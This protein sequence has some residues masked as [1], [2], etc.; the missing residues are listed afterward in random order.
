MVSYAV[1]IVD[2]Y[3]AVVGFFDPFQRT[4]DDLFDFNLETVI[5][6]KNEIVSE[7]NKNLNL[8]IIKILIL[9][10]LVKSK[11]N[12]L[13]SICSINFYIKRTKI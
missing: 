6:M 10:F 7:T 1:Q 11:F 5:F 3:R 12:N 4:Y 2:D 13:K 8:K 9:N